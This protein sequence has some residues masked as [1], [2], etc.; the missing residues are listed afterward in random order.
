VVLLLHDNIPSAV[1]HGLN[2][3]RAHN[4]IKIQ[5]FVLTRTP[6]A[7]LFVTIPPFPPLKLF[8]C[9]GGNTAFVAGVRSVAAVFAVGMACATSCAAEQCWKVGPE[10]G[11]HGGGTCRGYGEI[12]FDDG[13]GYLDAVEGVAVGIPEVEK[14]DE[15]DDAGNAYSS[16]AIGLY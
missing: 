4:T 1:S 14:L 16:D 5:N 7:Q 15:A 9:D 11:T 10:E 2:I 3:R 6:R 12:Y 13:Q 8:E